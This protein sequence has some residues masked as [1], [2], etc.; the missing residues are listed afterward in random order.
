MLL[1]ASVLCAGCERRNGS[2]SR[3]EGAPGTTST[4]RLKPAPPAPTNQPASHSASAP[5]DLGLAAEPRLPREA[6]P[7]TEAAT[8]ESEQ[9]EPEPV[10]PEPADLGADE[11]P[12]GAPS[13]SCVGGWIT[14]PR[15][16]P[17]RRVALNMM[18]TQ[19]GQVFMIAD[20][21][22]F[23]GP[24]DGDVMGQTGLVERWY[25]KGHLLNDPSYRRRW[26]IRRAKVGSGIDAV[27]R[28][29]SSGYGPN[30]WKRVGTQDAR[31]LDPFVHPCGRAAPDAK[32]M[33][34]PREVL[35]CL[36]GT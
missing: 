36:D 17:L 14:P 9:A 26:L 27:A 22:Y 24:E 8:A 29:D 34:L 2:A 4:H 12:S 3:S 5:T 23:V 13:P 21:R 25:V 28:Y 33:G 15:G 32:C 31:F 35:G 18:R 16:S 11:L 6:A 1:A 10:E 7:T 19:F 20:M 30:T